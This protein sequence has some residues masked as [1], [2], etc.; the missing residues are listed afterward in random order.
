MI[1]LID[2]GV[3]N[4]QAFSN[5]YKRLDITHRRVCTP[6]DLA[7]VTKLILP[8]VGVFD[9]TMQKFNSSGLRDDVE[10]LVLHDGLPILG[11]C[12]GMQMMAKSSEEGELH[13]LGWI[14]A[15]VLRLDTTN[16]SHRTR[17]PH[18][19][20]N[21]ALPKRN[22]GLF[23]DSQESGRFYF[24][25]SY[26]FSCNRTSDTVAEAEYGQRF[27]CAVQSGNL[28][29]VQFHPEKSHDA[30]EMLLQ[31]FAKL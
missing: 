1:G 10:R 19:G 13:G 7:G 17:L 27:C 15:A 11:V 21:D 31:N 23:G 30:G 12:V 26:F 9:D 6:D 2:Y 22:S 25:H 28:F 14:D 5:I 20:W 18:M 29:G 4:V 3:G 16:L 8:G 24:L